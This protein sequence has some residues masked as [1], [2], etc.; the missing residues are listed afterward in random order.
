MAGRVRRLSPVARFQEAF[1]AS[2]TDGHPNGVED[3]SLG[4]RETP[5]RQRPT[6]RAK[7]EQ[8]SRQGRDLLALQ[9]RGFRHPAFP[10]SE[11]NMRGR[12]EQI[13]GERDDD[14]IRRP[15]VPVVR[16]QNEDRPPLVELRSV[17]VAPAKSLGISRHI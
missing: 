12:L 11:A 16:R 13:R 3:G 4:L 8:L 17:E 6:E 14:H 7:F 5:V 15:L 1:A 10:P 2:V 9:D